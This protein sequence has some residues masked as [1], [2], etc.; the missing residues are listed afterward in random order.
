MKNANGKNFLNFV[1]TEKMG[2]QY[3][4]SYRNNF[5]DTKYKSLQLE[6]SI[7]WFKNSKI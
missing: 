5:F 3:V 2:F 7:D 6:R 4:Y 1:V